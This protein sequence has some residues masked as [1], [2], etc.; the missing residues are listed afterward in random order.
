M[1]YISKNA[2]KDV[3]DYISDNG[4]SII[5]TVNNKN[6][7]DFIGDHA[8]L[9]VCK[10]GEGAVFAE[11][12]DIMEMHGKYP[13]NAAFCAVCLDKYI[14]HRLD[15]T[16]QKVLDAGKKL[17]LVPVN[18]RQ[19]YTKCSCVTVDGN[20]VITSDDGIYSRLKEIKDISVLKIRS[21]HVLLPGFDYGFI[22]GASGRVGDEIIFNGDVSNHPDFEK[23]RSFIEERGLK[24]KSFPHPLRDI[25]SIVNVCNLTIL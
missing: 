18:V 7:G 12:E 3:I 8:D 11:K 14:V 23:I 4:H 13:E 15:I 22:G 24:I 2:Y 1:V 6:L 10:I 25:G 20:S 5:M 19:G 21:G 17:N 9:T 16:S